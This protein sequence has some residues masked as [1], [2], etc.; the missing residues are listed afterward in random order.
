MSSVGSVIGNVAINNN[1]IG[2]T[3][4]ALGTGNIVV[5]RNAADGNGTN[6][7]GGPSTPNYWG[8]NAGR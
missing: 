3:G 2:T 7:F 5:D 6:Y 4:F 1:S 8:I